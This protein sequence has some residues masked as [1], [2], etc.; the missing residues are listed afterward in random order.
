MNGQPCNVPSCHG[1]YKLS[2]RETGDWK[3]VYYC[4]A[5]G[6][7]Y[8]EETGLA[9]GAKWTGLAAS[10]VGLIGLGIKVLSGDDS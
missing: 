9:T 8:E 4:D 3:R 1:T 6:H 7:R 2:T 10:V 5:N